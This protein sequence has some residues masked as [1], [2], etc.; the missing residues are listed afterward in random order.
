MFKFFKKIFKRKSFNYL[1][2]W[3]VP[4]M[5]NGVSF[6]GGTTLT[7]GTF[8]NNNIILKQKQ[9][10]KLNV[11]PVKLFKEIIANTPEMDLSNLDK[12]IE[13]IK[14]RKKALEKY[15]EVKTEDEDEALLYLYARKKLLKIPHNFKWEVTTPELIN[16]LCNKYNV[17][18]QPI[19]AFYKTLPVEALKELKKFNKEYRKY[20]K[21]VPPFYK[22]IIEEASLRNAGTMTERKKDPI[23]L[24]KSPFGRW[25]F[26]LGAWDKEVLIVDDLLYN[27][28]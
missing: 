2:T 9:K 19:N 7:S 22:L 17:S 6:S 5:N 26:I 24:A 15:L 18:V 20:E 28:K 1:S 12:K 16:A 3:S 23:L 25:W 21:N 10:E 8:V 11:K 4:V 27:Y 14:N 13:I